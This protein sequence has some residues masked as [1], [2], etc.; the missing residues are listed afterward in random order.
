MH[1]H[2]KCGAEEKRRRVYAYAGMRQNQR[3]VD[4][5]ISVTNCIRTP[6]KQ[7]GAGVDSA[8]L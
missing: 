4:V 6:Q 7:N 2:R 8:P 5:Y 1:V 3:S